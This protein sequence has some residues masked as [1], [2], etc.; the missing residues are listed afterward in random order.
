MA[1]F[2]FLFLLCIFYVKSSSYLLSFNRDFPAERDMLR[3]K[4]PYCIVC[5]KKVLYIFTACKNMHGGGQ[6]KAPYEITNR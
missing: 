1:L 4:A 3:G 2:V 6:C 5:H